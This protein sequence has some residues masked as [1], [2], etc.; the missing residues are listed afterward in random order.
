MLYLVWIILHDCTKIF[1]F[2]MFY[3]GISWGK[4][5][6]LYIYLLA[7]TVHGWTTNRSKLET[8]LRLSAMLFGLCFN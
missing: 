3:H 7:N 6:K 8:K 4:K 1:Y 2:Y 5:C